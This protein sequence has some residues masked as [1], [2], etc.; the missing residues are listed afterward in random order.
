M[1]ESIHGSAPSDEI[2]RAIVEILQQQKSG[3]PASKLLAGLAKRGYSISQ[4]TL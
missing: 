2:D 1:H 3:C 4:P